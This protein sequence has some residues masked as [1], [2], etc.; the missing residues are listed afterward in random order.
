[1]TNHDE[2]DLFV[3]VARRAG[4]D[5]FRKQISAIVFSKD[6]PA[7]R[8]M[9]II[10]TIDGLRAVAARSNRY[11]PD[12]DEAAYEY[13]ETLKGPGNPAGLVKATVTIWIAE[14]PP[15]VGWKPVKGW[16]YWTEFAPIKE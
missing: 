8:K 14:P 11:R 4:L 6:D 3:E 10:T 12:E 9:S 1:D 16:A 13:D 5:P 7:K 2:F 15:M